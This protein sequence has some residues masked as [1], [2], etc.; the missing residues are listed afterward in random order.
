MDTKA[1]VDYD[2]SKVTWSAD[3]SRLYAAGRNQLADGQNPVRVFD[4]ADGRQLAA[5]PVSTI[6]VMDLQALADGRLIFAT[7]DPTWGI[8]DRDGRIVTRQNPPVTDHRG[9]FDGFRLSAGGDRLT[10]THLIL[11]QG[12][13]Q[14]QALH[15]DLRSLRLARGDAVPATGLS[16]PRRD[17]LEVKGWEGTYTPTLGGQRLQ[18][19]ELR[20]VPQPR[21]RRRRPPLRPG[22]RV[23][24]PL[25]RRQRQAAVGETGARHGLA[26]QHQC[27]R[28]LRRGRPRRRH[29]PLVSD[30]GRQRSPGPLRPCRRPALGGVDAGGLLRRLA[31]R[32]RV[33][34]LR[35]QPGPGQ[36]G[37]VCQRGAVAT[38]RS[39][40]PT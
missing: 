37:G 22:H 32:R 21:R 1:A 10:F 12:R 18:L 7:A 23:V 36:G 19:G 30:A 26:G 5:W 29:D 28:P 31:R 14:R 40:G 4:P 20:D 3:G 2:L 39:T 11:Q 15:F 25:V 24:C 34:G 33:D 16:A 8:V 38:S 27:R 35:A 17:G 13:W 9:N 6:T